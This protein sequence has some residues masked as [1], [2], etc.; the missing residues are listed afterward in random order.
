MRE[1]VINGCYGGFSLSDVA[2]EW[3][4]V[5]RGWNVRDVNYSALRAG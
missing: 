1:V 4:I 3:L 2:F 5:N